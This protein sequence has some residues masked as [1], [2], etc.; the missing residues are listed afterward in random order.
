[1]T[2]Q[3]AELASLGP[4]PKGINNLSP[5]SGLAA[6]GA[7][8]EAVNVLL[9]A[10]GH[11]RRRDGS[12]KLVDVARGH[13]LWSAPD[14]APFALFVSN[15][16]LHALYPDERVEATTIEVGD[17][18][19]AF[20]IFG[21]R[22]AWTNDA[23][24]GMVDM[25]LSPHRWAPEQPPGP[26]LLMAVSGQA[27]EPGTVQVVAT[28]VD[29]LG[30]ESGCGVASTIELGEG[31]GVEA[32]LPMALDPSIK[33]ISIYVTESNGDVLRLHTSV[34]AGE[35]VVM[36]TG[37]ARGRVLSTQH[38]QP[39][40]CGHL[41]AQHNGRQWVASNDTLIWSE[42]LRYGLWSPAKNRVRFSDRISVMAPVGSG[43]D[44]AGVFVAAGGRVYW[45]GGADPSN[46]NQ[47]IVS[48][49]GAIA[50]T[51]VMIAG[52]DVGLET[53][54]PVACW[55]SRNGQY[56][57]GLPGG[58]L[59]QLKLN[60][61]VTDSAESG[62]SVVIEQD[63]LHRIVTSLQAPQAQSM[64]IGDYAAIHVIHQDP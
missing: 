12:T 31:E 24:C 53:A 55:L 44:G 63:G 29:E 16:F 28:F 57:A 20:A 62:A 18:P 23:G 51:L 30:R 47:T 19:T 50:G 27:G 2:I 33:E 22:I 10:D 52:T 49:H 3:D 14:F 60:E 43:S 6:R 36:L 48:M 25:E 37:Y 32:I 61:A 40:P 35:S 59:V 54:S 11:P 34:P 46:F 15:G 64:G 5:E 17:L 45:L 41:L 39:M 42:P 38:L 58:Q 4:W 8:R 1:M 13:S 9:D 56:V 7:L 26:P 21:E